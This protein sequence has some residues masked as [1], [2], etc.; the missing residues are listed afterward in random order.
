M[1]PARHDTANRR[2][3]FA[4]LL[5][6]RR[7]LRRLAF[8]HD[9]KHPDV[10]IEAETIGWN[11]Y[12]PKMATQASGRNLADVVQMD[13]RY[14][15]EYARRNQLE[16]L[17]EYL[18]NG[19]DLS[20]FD[21][22]FLDSGRFEGTLYAIPW[23]VNSIACYYDM[24]VAQQ[25]GVTMPDWRWTWDDLKTVARELKKGVPE[26]YAAVADKGAWEPGLEFFLRQ[27]GKAL[28]TEDGELAF[29][30]EDVR[31]SGHAFECRINAEDA[32]NGFLPTP[33]TIA[34]YREPAGPGVRVDSGVA[35]GSEVVGLYDPLVAK[36]IAWDTDRERARRRM[37]RALDE[38][39][40]DGV[41]TLVGFHK[42]LLR[43]PCFVA[44]ETCFGL[45]EEIALPE[46]K[47][48]AR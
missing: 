25:A 20:R 1:V 5:E 18:G 37:L 40:I 17:D 26:G 44:G 2:H 35:A 15:Y 3:R 6:D 23:T 36:L 11:D 31:L 45:V 21:P 38:Y 13:Y 9:D 48:R 46:E 28:Y 32:A 41:T 7:H 43:H 16:P 10:S 30:Q 33:G 34:A 19:L 42:A 47:P 8:R 27:H 29:A 4:L 12:W 39:A 14:L 24:P 22:E